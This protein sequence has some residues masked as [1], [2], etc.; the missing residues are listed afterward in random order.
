MTNLIELVK[1]LKTDS[2][3]YLMSK[4]K[5]KDDILKLAAEGK[6]YSEIQKELGC[7]KGTIAY[8]LGEGQKEKVAKR[9]KDNV[10][11]KKVTRFKSIKD[12]KNFYKRVYDFQERTLKFSTEDVLLRLLENPVCYLTG[13]VIDLKDPTSYELDHIVPKSRGGDSSL[14]NL[15]FTTK[16]ANRSKNNLLLA[17]FIQ[18]C[19][20]V[21]EHNGYKVEKLETKASDH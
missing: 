3:N 6:S 5:R 1:L 4:P 7:S 12:E 16:I 18:L 20:D 21:L 10:L 17:E 2:N 11:Q 8:H 14:E 19:R 13:K 9:Q 15:G